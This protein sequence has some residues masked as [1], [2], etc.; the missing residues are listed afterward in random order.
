MEG[1]I[2]EPVPLYAQGYFYVNP[3]NYIDQIVVF[4]YFDPAGYYNE[5]LKDPELLEDELRRIRENM[6]YFLNL[7][8]IIINGKRSSPKVHWVK[9]GF[10]G[11]RDLPYLTFHISFP[12]NFAPGVNVYEDTYEEE[13]A[14]YDYSVHWFFP[15]G[16]RV[17]E[18]DLG[19]DYEL[20]EG[21]RVLKFNVNSGTYIRG[22]ERIA[23]ELAPE[24]LNECART[25]Q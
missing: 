10:R 7:E 19:V 17:I 15:E 20:L 21:G 16:A 24:Y 9:L 18:A 23:F 2:S 6:Q 3:C 22:Y 8:E 1:R 11:R 4:D 25:R 14:E 12:G 13:V 5:L